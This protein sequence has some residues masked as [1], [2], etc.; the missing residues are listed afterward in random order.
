M[1]GLPGQCGRA[2]ERSRECFRK[3]AIGSLPLIYDDARSSLARAAT[4]GIKPDKGARLVLDHDP[5]SHRSCR[6]IRRD[7]PGDCPEPGH[8]ITW[9]GAGGMLAVPH[10]ERQSALQER[11]NL[12]PSLLD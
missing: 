2:R 1:G 8:G 10:W 12:D 11:R 7:S 3:R 9:P 6:V 5:P 4:D